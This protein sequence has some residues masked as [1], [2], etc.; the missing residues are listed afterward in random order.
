MKARI[1]MLFELPDGIAP[2]EFQA[3]IRK[4]VKQEII[5][6]CFPITKGMVFPNSFLFKDEKDDMEG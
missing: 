1:I 4:E 5:S 6:V 3:G 2:I